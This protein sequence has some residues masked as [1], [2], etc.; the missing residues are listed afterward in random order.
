MTAFHLRILGFVALLVLL[1]GGGYYAGLFTQEAPPTKPSQEAAGVAVEEAEQPAGKVTLRTVYL[2]KPIGKAHRVFLEWQADG[3][4]QL[5]LDETACTINRLGE[6]KP[7]AAGGNW[8][9]VK[10]ETAAVK[11]PGAD[12]HALFD[13]SGTPD[14]H[15]RIVKPSG[16]LSYYRL[17]V[18]DNSNR[19]TRVITLE[20]WE[21]AAEKKNR[22]SLSAQ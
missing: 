3:T 7:K 18:L 4:G 13:I 1:L 15:F 22:A 8:L 2:D 19:V 21:L 6:E 5:M 11:E 20:R 10:Y 12:P 14:G 17:L 9:E 16:N